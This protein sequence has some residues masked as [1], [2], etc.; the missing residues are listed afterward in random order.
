MIMAIHFSS[1]T[2]E[3]VLTKDTS[4][5][6][7]I[8]RVG[9]SSRK[10][11]LKPG[12]ITTL[13]HS[14]SAKQ[15]EALSYDSDK[16]SVENYSGRID[17]DDRGIKESGL[18]T[19]LFGGIS[20]IHLR[21]S[22]VEF[23][24]ESREFNNEQLSLND[25]KDILNE[26]SNYKH[27][28]EKIHSSPEIKYQLEKFMA[29]VTVSPLLYFG[30]KLKHAD[31]S[32]A[33]GLGFNGFDEESNLIKMYDASGSEDINSLDDAYLGKVQPILVLNKLSELE[34]HNKNAYV[35]D[36][37]KLGIVPPEDLEKCHH[38]SIAPP[39]KL[40]DSISLDNPQNNDN[41]I[42]FSTFGNY[43]QKLDETSTDYINRIQGSFIDC[44]ELAKFWTIEDGGEFPLVDTISDFKKHSKLLTDKFSNYSLGLTNVSPDFKEFDLVN[45]LSNLLVYQTKMNQYHSHNVELTNT[46]NDGL[47]NLFDAVETI[48]PRAKEKAEM[49]FN[50]RQSAYVA[51]DAKIMPVMDTLSTVTE[52]FN[53]K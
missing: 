43:V 1:R 48:V 29:D 37:L 35:V 44:T 30:A 27:L 7:V 15:N 38:S 49:V 5:E 3:L 6:D 26:S 28:E 45:E 21:P 14:H 51:G 19:H 9:K 8:L 46:V 50:I 17:L 42:V 52:Y 22:I 41:S 36:K 23:Y 33:E 31:S 4:I 32:E 10:G 12:W 40:G 34:H 2:N 25:A 39:I 24:L 20:D 13:D 53:E 11:Q 18:L 47:N 16:I